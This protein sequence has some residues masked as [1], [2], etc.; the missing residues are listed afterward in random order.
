[1]RICRGNPLREIGVNQ[2]KSLLRQLASISVCSRV[3]LFLAL[4]GS[5]FSLFNPTGSAQSTGGRVRG[6]VTDAS[7]GAVGEVTVRL[8]KTATNV[9]RQS[10]PRSTGGNFFLER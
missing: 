4:L 6:T 8:G 10:V 2:M 5:S 9:K 3:M 1:M 7:G